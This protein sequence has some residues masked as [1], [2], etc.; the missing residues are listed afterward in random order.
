MIIAQA[1]CARKPVVAT[2]A[3]GVPELMRDGETGFVVDVGDQEEFAEKAV[4]LLLDAELRRR[5][6]ERGREV[7]ERLFRTDV[8]AAKTKLVYDEMLGE[9]RESAS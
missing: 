8:V 3:G 9:A 4:A 2:A 6:G 1:M 7:A 5:L